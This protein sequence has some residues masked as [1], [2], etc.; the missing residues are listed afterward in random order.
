MLALVWP[1]RADWFPPR[2]AAA[3]QLWSIWLGYLTGASALFVIDYLTTSPGDAFYGLRAYP[4]MAVLASLAFLVL[5]SS[6]WGYCY[7][8]GGLFLALAVAMTQWLPAAPLAFG[9]AWAASLALVGVR[10]D[11]LARTGR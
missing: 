7:V 4:P 2:G 6:Y 1:R 11:R 9:V 8:I 5:G 10:L 3:R